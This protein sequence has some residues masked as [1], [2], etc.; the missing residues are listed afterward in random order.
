[1]L[2]T[3]FFN[4]PISMGRSPRHHYHR[5]H[6][7]RGPRLWPA[8]SP[9]APSA[10][11][12]EQLDITILENSPPCTPAVRHHRS[13]SLHYFRTNW[14]ENNASL[15]HFDYTPRDNTHI[16]TR[17]SCPATLDRR[18]SLETGSRWQLCALASAYTHF[19][20]ILPIFFEVIMSRA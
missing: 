18:S 8:I 12:V 14:N 2:F 20:T 5:R 9:A 7:P 17:I 19:M 13:L 11:P 4:I 10:M 1:M 16:T 3:N 15:R 6:A